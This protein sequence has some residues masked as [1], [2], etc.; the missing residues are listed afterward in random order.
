[1]RPAPKQQP[2]LRVATMADAKLLFVW[3]NDPETRAASLTTE[4]LDWDAHLA[5]LGEV[6][7]NSD[8]RLWVAEEGGPVGQVRLD[9]HGDVEIISVSVAPSAR[10]RGLAARIIAAACAQARGTVVARVRPDND[11][12]LRA[13]AA[14]GFVRT[15]NDVELRWSTSTV[16]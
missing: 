14:A 8:R 3:R 7:E 16:P 6:L 2:V 13:F 10:G 9:R 11:R 1:M 15:T 4:P 5:W 12:S